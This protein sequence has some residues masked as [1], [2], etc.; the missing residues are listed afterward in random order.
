M[1]YYPFHI[2]DYVAHTAHLDPIEDIA[3]RR[4]MDAYYM[5]ES[6]LPADVPSCARLIRMKSNLAEVE[7]VLGEFFVLTDAGW[8]HKRCDAEIA[9]MIDKSTKAKVSSDLAM[10][11]KRAKRKPFDQ[12]NGASNGQ[13]NDQSGDASSG[14]S[15]DGSNAHLP[16]TQDP[17]PKTQYSPNPPPGDSQG[18]E[19]GEV[20]PADRSPTSQGAVCMAMKSVGISDVNPG[21]TQLLALLESGTPL[22]TFVSVARDCVARNK[23]SFRYVLSVVE[24]QELEARE[25]AANL[26]KPKV[27]HGA[28]GA[29]NKHAAAYAT[30]L[31]D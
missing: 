14:G 19:G 30:I 17:I 8:T 31:G 2:G 28:P 3:Y 27:H 21:H 4:L 16:K 9:R 25:L 22:E 15:V 18:A 23:G 13:S 7:Q 26:A 10:A 24:R 29:D 20:D 1:N 11:A 5:A 6:A 12:S